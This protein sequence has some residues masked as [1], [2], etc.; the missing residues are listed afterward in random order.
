M[1]IINRCNH[2]TRTTTWETVGFNKTNIITRCS[3]ICIT[4]TT[5]TFTLVITNLEIMVNKWTME[6][7]SIKTLIMVA[8]W[9]TIRWTTQTTRL[10]MEAI[11]TVILEGR[12]ITFSN[13]FR[14]NKIKRNQ[15]SKIGLETNRFIEWRLNLM[16]VLLFKSS[17][18]M[19]KKENR[20]I[21]EILKK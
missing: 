15:H 16:I 18:Q 2:H 7:T 21:L 1:D 6:T 3:T 9:T 17:C 8:Q 4:I 11:K 12:I 19:M 20:Q 5:T 14:M 13:H 10:I